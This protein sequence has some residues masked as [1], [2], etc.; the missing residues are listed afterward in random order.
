MEGRLHYMFVILVS[1]ISVFHRAEQTWG[2][3]SSRLFS[4]QTQLEKISFIWVALLLALG[5]LS[6]HFGSSTVGQWMS[7]ILLLTCLKVPCKINKYR[8]KVLSDLERIKECQ[9]Q[10]GLKYVMGSKLHSGICVIKIMESWNARGSVSFCFDLIC[11]VETALMM[12]T[13]TKHW[14]PIVFAT[15]LR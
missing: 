4:F 12:D 15:P 10:H 7:W 2:I 11:S 9:R 5:L 8:E 14:H 1:L 6:M 3:R 13:V